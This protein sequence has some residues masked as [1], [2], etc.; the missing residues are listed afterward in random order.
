MAEGR[1]SRRE[2]CSRTGAAIGAVILGGFPRGEGRSQGQPGGQFGRATTLDSPYTVGMMTFLSG[3]SVVLAA[4]ML[5]GHILA[6][7]EV[8]ATGGL[9]G[10]RRVETITADEGAGTDANVG[11]LKRMKREAKIDAFMGVASSA[12]TAAL[13]P[14]AE[15]LR[16]PTLFVDG[17]TDLLFE[18]VLPRPQ[19]VF[20]VLNPQSADG[21]ACAVAVA[22]TWPE[23]RRIAFINPDYGYGRSAFDHFHVAIRKLLPGVHV[24]SEMWAPVGTTDFAGL[25][26]Q[27][28][29]AR[30]DL[31]VSALWG[32]DYR[33]FYRQA[34]GVGLFG[35]TKCVT[36]I[37]FGVTP[38]TIDTDHPEAVMAGARAGYYWNLSSEA[39]WPANSRFVRRYY[40]RWGEYPNFEAEGGY[41]AMHLLR[42]AIERAVQAT[43]GW[44]DDAAIVRHLEGLSWESPAGP[45]RIRP[46]NHQAYRDAVISFT[47]HDPRY[48]FTVLD[49]RR[50]IT[51]P[52]H[53]ITAPPGWPVG[54]PTS[55]YTWIERTW[56]AAR[57]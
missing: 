44:P 13:G 40:A 2:F 22:R 30:P 48:P 35:K 21:A 1:V 57:P 39:R 50:V 3:P 36:T 27:V 33:R 52:I 37:A 54:H 23:V 29:G 18:R 4:P 53:T 51:V 28:S 6:V 42:V 55:T 24:V 31:L 14:V 15:D 7:E 8:N 10:R 16:I 17:S 41:T 19:Y 5:K 26:G 32:A 46:D 43:G 56:P 38:H 45:I 34:Q 12:N 20:R 11:A 49:Q 25:I 47:R 9:A